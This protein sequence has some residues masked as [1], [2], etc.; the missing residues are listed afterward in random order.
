MEHPYKRMEDSNLPTQARQG[1]VV[2]RQQGPVGPNA[3]RAQHRAWARREFLETRRA[4][5]ESQSKAVGDSSVARGTP[6]SHVG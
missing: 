1:V 3:E 5:Q 4:K 2:S 6:G